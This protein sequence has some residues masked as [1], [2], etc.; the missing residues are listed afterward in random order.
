MG[1]ALFPA[2]SDYLFFVSRNNGTHQFSTNLAEHNRAVQHYQ[3]ALRGGV[4]KTD[5]RRRSAC[6]CALALRSGCRHRIFD[7]DSPKRPAAGPEIP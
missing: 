5:P 4:P 1:A 6:G 2:Q 3:V 7:A